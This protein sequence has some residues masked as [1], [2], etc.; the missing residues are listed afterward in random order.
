VTFIPFGL[1]RGV[2][3]YAG[4]ARRGSRR[5][6]GRDVRVRR[7]RRARRRADLGDFPKSV[8]VIDALICT[9]LVGASRFWERPRRAGCRRSTR[10]GGAR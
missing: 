3:R 2:W 9:V 1:Y 7:L 10:R 4:R 8:F 5:R 6:S